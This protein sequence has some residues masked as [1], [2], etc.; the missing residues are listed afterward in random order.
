[1]RDQIRRLERHPSVLT[2]LYGS[3]NPPPP[4]VEKMY[5]Q[6]LQECDRPNPAV[7]SASATPTTVGPRRENDRSLYMWPHPS[8]T[9][10]RTSAEHMALTLRRAPARRS[11]DR[12]PTPPL[13]ADYLRPIDSVWEYHAGA[14]PVRLVY[15]RRRST[16]AMAPRPL[17]KS[18]PAKPKCRPGP[19]SHDGSVW[20]RQVTSTV[21]IQ[22]ML[23]CL[24]KMIWHLYD[25]YLRPGGSYSASSSPAS[26]CMSS[27]RMTTVAWRETSPPCPGCTPWP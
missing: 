4:K 26:H 11:A 20:A 6:I 7:S 17:P 23:N 3:D 25:W 14:C 21:V 19:P 15:S 8:G 24:A 10:I 27:T 22:W 16:G 13:P 9:W 18:I 12:E 5:L 1:M 2:W